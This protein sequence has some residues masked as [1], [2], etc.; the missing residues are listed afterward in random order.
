[1]NKKRDKN[2]RFF[3]N[4]FFPK[5]R[6]G[7]ITTQQIVLLIILIVSFAVILFFLIRLNLGKTSDQEVCHNSVVTRG[8]GVIPQESIPL[9]CKTSYIC[10]T[11]DGSCESFTSPEIKKITTQNEVYDILANQMA[12]CWWMFGEGKLNYV[13]KTFDKELYCS[14]CSQIRFD[15]SID[16][17]NNGKINQ[18]DLYNYLAI[19]NMSG[20]DKTYLDYLLGITNSQAI[21]EE[22]KKN[23]SD[24]TVIDIN[25]QHSIVMGIFSKVGLL[26]WTAIGVAAGGLIAVGAAILTGGVSIPITIVIATGAAAGGAGGYFIGTALQGG[27]GNYFLSP[28]IIETSSADFQ[29]LQCSDIKTLA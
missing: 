8:S 19:T 18:K 14:I 26:S 10:I 22:L 2:Q 4:T 13:G 12:D 3:Q 5:S 9:T 29:K 21:E 20:S 25:K 23:N 1:M 16:I 7:E 6:R 11:K 27:S 24:F 15:N 28:T 17:F